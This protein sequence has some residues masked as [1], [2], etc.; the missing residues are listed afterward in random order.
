[1]KSF[2]TLI[3]VDF[4]EFFKLNTTRFKKPY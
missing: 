3:Y 2:L 1:M 4:I